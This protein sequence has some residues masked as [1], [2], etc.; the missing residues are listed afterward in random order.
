MTYLQDP[1]VTICACGCGTPIQNPDERGRPRK[2]QRGHNLRVKHPL[3]GRENWWKGRSH[4]AESRAKISRAA[5]RPKPYLRGERNG[6]AGRTGASNPNW[7][8]GVTPERQALYASGEWK[9]VAR[10]VRVR[11]GGCVECGAVAGTHVHHVRS[12]ADYPD[13]R[14]DP[15]NLVTLCREHHHDAHRKEVVK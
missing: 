13:L 5:S 9:R 15:D 2:F 1:D 3:E 7:K 11:D 14:L 6:M 8:G 10:L 4:S 12:F